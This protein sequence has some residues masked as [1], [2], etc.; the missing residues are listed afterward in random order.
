MEMTPMT[1]RVLHVSVCRSAEDNFISEVEGGA[2]LGC[3]GAA[4]AAPG[5]QPAARRARARARAAAAPPADAVRITELVF[6]IYRALVL[7][8]SLPTYGA[9]PLVRTRR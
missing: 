2:L 5:A 6:Y 8:Q 1:Y 9:D 7:K 4:H 3:R